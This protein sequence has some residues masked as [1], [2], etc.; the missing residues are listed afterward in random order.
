[1]VTYT[2][3]GGL[4]EPSHTAGLE[5]VGLGFRGRLGECVM[6]VMAGENGGIQVGKTLQIPCELM[7]F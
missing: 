7:I 5:L 4:P 3:F 1:M 2:A 6:A